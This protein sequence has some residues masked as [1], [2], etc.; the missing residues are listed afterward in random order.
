[1]RGPGGRGPGSPGPRADAFG[2]RGLID[3]GTVPAAG[4]TP[5]QAVD[6]LLASP[7]SGETTLLDADKLL[8]RVLERMDARQKVQAR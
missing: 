3:L 4:A 1:M 8:L 7:A 2:Q 5:P 6:E